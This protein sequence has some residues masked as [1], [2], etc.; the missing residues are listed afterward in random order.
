MLFNAQISVFI[1]GVLGD[2]DTVHQAVPCN[3]EESNLSFTCLLPG[4]KSCVFIYGM[5]F[6]VLSGLSVAQ[7]SVKCA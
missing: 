4:L 2:L 5:I 1:L 7:L 6:G 3:G